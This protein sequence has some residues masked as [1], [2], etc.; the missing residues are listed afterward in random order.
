MR[1]IRPHHTATHCNTPKHTATHCNTLQHTPR[2]GRFLKLDASGL[3]I[4]Q[5]T[6]THRN[7]L[8]HTAT[9]CNTL[10]HTATH[11]NTLQHTATHSQV[12]S[13]FEKRDASGLNTTH[14]PTAVFFVCYV[15][16]AGMI[17]FVNTTHCNTLQH[18]ATHC[19]TLQYTATH[20]NTLHCNTLQHIVYD[21]F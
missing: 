11:C 8:R 2:C 6:A 12:R 19:N 7:T 5:H 18:T 1:Y 17:F 21:A 20:C 10:Q 4:L 3:I 9:H 13:I 14:K 15:L 16:L